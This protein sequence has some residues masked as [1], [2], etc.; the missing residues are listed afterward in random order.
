MAFD[1][2]TYNIINMLLIVICILLH[3]LG[4][5]LLVKLW[6]RN[7]QMLMIIHLSVA[8]LLCSIVRLIV[9]SAAQYIG[10]P[11]PN[12]ACM[13]VMGRYMAPG[14]GAGG[15]TTASNTTLGGGG[16]ITTNGTQGNGTGGP[17]GG[18]PGGFRPPPADIVRAFDV[19]NYSSTLAMTGFFFIIFLIMLVLMVDRALVVVLKAKYNTVMSIRNTSIMMALCWIVGIIMCIAFP[20]VRHIHDYKHNYHFEYHIY[21][22]CDVVFI[23]VAI[24]SYIAVLSLYSGYQV[25]EDN[26]GDDKS[27]DDA[28]TPTGAGPGS[29][30]VVRI[31]RM[32]QFYIPLLILITYFIFV[33]LPHWIYIGEKYPEQD[34]CGDMDPWRAMIQ[35]LIIGY[36]SDAVVYI[37]LQPPVRKLLAQW[38]C[39]GGAKGGSVAAQPIEMGV[40]NSTVAI[41]E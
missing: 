22:V 11:P 24:V 41:V 29:W 23:V 26:I 40:E 35:L 3:G 8:E 4:I 25:Q 18:P 39:C 27:A 7:A 6:K 37:F 20:L 38:F 34:P 1:Q 16:N 28:A 30:S 5:G 14:A 15:N 12:P 33:I 2:E 31:L 19:L 13:G 10:P 36:M 9:I 21:L 32:P 17:P